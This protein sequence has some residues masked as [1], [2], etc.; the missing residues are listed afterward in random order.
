MQHDR[1]RQILEGPFLL[2]DQSRE[3]RATARDGGRERKA[4]SVYQGDAGWDY[5]G[6]D[7]AV[8]DA[9]IEPIRRRGRQPLPIGGG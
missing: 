5:R 3:P 8:N 7:G 2:A 4:I 1:M 9:A 6:V